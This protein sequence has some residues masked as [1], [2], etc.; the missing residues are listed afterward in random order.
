MPEY[1]SDRCVPSD[2][3]ECIYLVPPAQGLK[4]IQERK[5]WSINCPVSFY[6]QCN[7]EVIMILQTLITQCGYHQ[8]IRQEME[9][10]N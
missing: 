1:E 2:I 6:R 10:Q 5:F 7:R 8:K 3:S 4:Y 9:K